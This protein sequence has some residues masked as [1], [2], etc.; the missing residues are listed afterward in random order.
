[1]GVWESIRFGFRRNGRHPAVIRPYCMTVAQVWRRV[2]VFCPDV[3]AGIR[4]FRKHGWAGAAL[5]AAY[6][7]AK[8]PLM[9]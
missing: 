2:L 8:V 5:C 1:M 6:F 4:V 3:T 7:F 9:P